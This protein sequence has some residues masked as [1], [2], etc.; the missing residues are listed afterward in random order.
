MVNKIKTGGRNNSTFVLREAAAL[1]L[2]VPTAVCFCTDCSSS[3]MGHTRQQSGVSPSPKK[4]G[5]LEGKEEE[6]LGQGLPKWLPDLEQLDSEM[7][8]MQFQIVS[9]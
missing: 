5:S 7:A 3:V 6:V 9:P 1:L 4:L 8:M 2:D